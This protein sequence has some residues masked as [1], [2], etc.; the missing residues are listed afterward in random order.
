MGV[1]RQ[2]G[3]QEASSSLLGA[4][5]TRMLRATGRGEAHL[6]MGPAALQTEASKQGPPR[7]LLDLGPSACGSRSP[8]HHP[9]APKHQR[10]LQRPGLRGLIAWA[11]G[12]GARGCCQRERSPPRDRTY[13]GGPGS[14]FSLIGFHGWQVD[15]INQGDDVQTEALLKQR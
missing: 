6:P 5:V 8:G 12:V 2:G 13:A 14:R 10:H 1:L 15:I 4:W 11:A 3:E 9:P 7:I